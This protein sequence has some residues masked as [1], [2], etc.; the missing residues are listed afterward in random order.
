MLGLG[1]TACLLCDRRVA[2][3]DAFAVRHR[4]GLVV[5]RRCIRRWEASAGRCPQCRAPLRGPQ[6]V[7]IFLEGAPTA[8]ADCGARHL[9][10]A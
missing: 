9:T 8:G 6:E 3:S 2:R 7:G 1:K 5:C 4:R 10:P